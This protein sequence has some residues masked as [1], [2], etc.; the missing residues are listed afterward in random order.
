MPKD[1]EIAEL[2][3]RYEK[4]RMRAPFRERQLLVSIVEGGITDP[5]SGVELDSGVKILLD[6][7][8]RLRCARKAGLQ[9]VPFESLGGDEPSAIIGLLK[10]ANRSAISLMEQAMFVEELHKTHGLSVAE[11]AGRLQKSKAWVNVRLSTFSEMSEK[12]KASILS[13]DF[14]LYSYLYTLHP[15]RR[16][17]GCASKDEIDEFVGIASGKALSAREIERLAAAYFRGG[18]EMREQLKKGD[19][20]WCLEEMRRREEAMKSSELTESENKI[21]RD[22]EIASGAMGRLGLKLPSADV[23]KPAFK[24]RADLLADK[25]LSQLNPFTRTMKEFYD[26]CRKA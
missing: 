25:I 20:G 26:R 13:G 19:L 3:L 4:S 14:P 12:T 9:I 15:F 1:V 2:D 6:G 23:A 11:I 8:K 22:L 10:A 18:D 17:N 5:L 24:A 7:F 21:V 16:L